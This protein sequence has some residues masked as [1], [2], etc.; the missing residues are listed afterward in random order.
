MLVNSFVEPNATPGI[1]STTPD[2]VP[3]K[4][5]PIRKRAILQDRAANDHNPSREKTQEGGKAGKSN[6]RPGRVALKDRAANERSPSRRES[7]AQGEVEGEGDKENER[8]SRV[9]QK[10]RA[11]KDRNT[12]RK[13]SQ[14]QDGGEGDNDKGNENRVER[15]A[16]YLIP[17]EKTAEF[18]GEDEDNS[19]DK[20]KEHDKSLLPKASDST[21]LNDKHRKR[22]KD[23]NEHQDQDRPQSQPQSQPQGY[24][25]RRFYDTGNHLWWTDCGYC[26]GQGGETEGRPWREHDREGAHKRVDAHTKNV[27]INCI[28]CRFYYDHY[29]M[30]GCLPGS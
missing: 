1:L 27:K 3:I 23:E 18:A 25:P 30:I 21:A 8:P 29:G 26:R 14:V 17:P 16:N 11:A 2:L 15:V 24:V 10:D 12:S 13:K 22:F 5:P 20:G 4:K 19:D 9:S 28:H 7:K 6:E